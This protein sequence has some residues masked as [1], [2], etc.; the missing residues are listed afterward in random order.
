MIL[1]LIEADPAA[2]LDP[3]GPVLRELVERSVRV[4]ADVVG[5]RPDASRACARSSTTA[6]RSP[7][8]SSR[9]RASS[10]GTAHAVSVGLVYAAAARPTWQ[11]FSTT[12]RPTGTARC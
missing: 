3:T 4:K 9:S 1:D 6:T 11:A 10:G 5:R 2:A 8:R 12:P 7:T